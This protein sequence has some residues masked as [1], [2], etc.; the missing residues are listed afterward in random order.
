METDLEKAAQKRLLFFYDEEMTKFLKNGPHSSSLL[1]GMRRKL[2]QSLI[3]TYFDAVRFGSGYSN[4]SVGRT[5]K[6]LNVKLEQKFKVH[7]SI[8][9]K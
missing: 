1:H 9:V 6:E 5:R 8:S 2:V 7:L 3:Q 4:G